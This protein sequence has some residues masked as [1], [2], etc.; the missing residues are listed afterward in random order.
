MRRL[1]IVL[2]ALLLTLFVRALT[3]NDGSFALS[4][5]V[6]HT[7]TQTLLGGPF[8]AETWVGSTDAQSLTGGGFTIQSG[9]AI[10]NPQSVSAVSVHLL[11]AESPVT[12][13]LQYLMLLMLFTGVVTLR[14]VL[15][16]R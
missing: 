13:P 5:T 3:A 7:A 8:S 6:A 12:V 4:G 15:R 9:H 2:L 11:T 16:K 1:P 14:M 10:N